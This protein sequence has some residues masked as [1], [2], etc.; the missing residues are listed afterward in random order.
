VNS[1]TQKLVR[2]LLGVAYDAG[3]GHIGSALSV[4]DLI[5]CVY[6]VIEPKRKV[7]ANQDRFVLSK[8]HAALALYVVLWNRGV[9][10]DEELG[11][12]CANGSLFGVHPEP[13]T[14][15]VDFGTGSLGTGIGYAVGSALAMRMKRGKNRVVCL[16][17]DSELNEGSTWEALMFAGHH[18]LNNLTI[19]LDQNEQQ[20]LGYTKDILDTS[21]IGEH[22]QLMGF[23]VSEI[24]GHDNRQI[25]DVLNRVSEKPL[26]VTAHTVLGHGIQF[27]ERQVL[28][29]YKSL[30]ES[31][32]QAALLELIDA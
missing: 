5:D 2:R 10:S 14:P 15:G 27:M 22:M 4:I 12:Y 13:F 17:S 8:G 31:E 26:F 1:K 3:E 9:I 23:D 24:D 11:S 29:H 7:E 16:L 25:T 20:A 28:W 6:E 30:S 21:R 19:I 32:Y 18:S